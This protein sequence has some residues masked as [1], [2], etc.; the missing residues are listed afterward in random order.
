MGS[1]SMSARRLT[2]R[3][4]SPAFSVPTTPCPPMLRVTS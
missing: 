3:V 2:L 1:A 4:P